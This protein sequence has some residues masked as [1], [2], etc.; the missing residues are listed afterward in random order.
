MPLADGDESARSRPIATPGHAPDHLVFVAGALCFTGDAVLGEGSVFVA[1]DPGALGGYLAG[2]RAAARPR[3]RRAAARATGRWCTD[4][5]A[6]LDGYVAHR[7]ERERRL[8]AALDAGARTVDELLDAAWDDGPA[9]C[10][11]GGRDA[12]RAPRQAREEGRLPEG[13][14]ERPHWFAEL[15]RHAH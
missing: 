1:P 6:K 10:A 9:G 2:A 8:V 14:E 7:L 13:V 3:L 4:P 11:C 5:A 12:G 15:G